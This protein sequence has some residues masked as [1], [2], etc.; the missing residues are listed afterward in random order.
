MILVIEVAEASIWDVLSL[1]SV[2][3]TRGLDGIASE[4]LFIFAKHT[5][6]LFGFFIAYSRSI[7][8]Y[9]FLWASTWKIERGSFYM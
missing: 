5:T 4:S 2:N 6:K 7:D 3:I 1:E 9:L 8:A